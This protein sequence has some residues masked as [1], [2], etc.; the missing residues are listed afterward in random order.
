LPDHNNNLGQ[1]G[2]WSGQGNSL[3]KIAESFSGKSFAQ[4]LSMDK[5]SAFIMQPV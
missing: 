5:S 1:Y 4:T 3:E 2:S